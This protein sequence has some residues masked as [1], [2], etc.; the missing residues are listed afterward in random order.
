MRECSSLLPVSHK[1]IGHS[2]G[3]TIHGCPLPYDTWPKIFPEE[4][5][6]IEIQ[7]FQLFKFILAV[8]MYFFS[9]QGFV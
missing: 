2:K 5:A 4:R 7:C 3:R 9:S 6:Y 1:V 8:C